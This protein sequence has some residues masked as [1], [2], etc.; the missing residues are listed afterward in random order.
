MVYGIRGKKSSKNVL[1]RVSRETRNICIVYQSAKEAGYGIIP[2][3]APSVDMRVLCE[4]NLYANYLSRSFLFL[5]CFLNFNMILYVIFRFVFFCN[6]GNSRALHGVYRM[7]DGVHKNTD[8]LE[9]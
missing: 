2:L 6:R 5:P 9:H 7:A 3:P 4:S 8:I 1:F